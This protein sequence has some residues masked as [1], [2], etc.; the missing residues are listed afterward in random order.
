MDLAG[1]SIYNDKKEEV[2]NFGKYKNVPVEEVF[3]RDLGY[4]SWMMQGDFPLNT[5]KVITNIKL[6]M[7]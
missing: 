5:K 1:R 2:F 3:N 7:K 4:Y 6:R